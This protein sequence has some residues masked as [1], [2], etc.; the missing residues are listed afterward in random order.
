M[1][2]TELF[3][4]LENQ[5]GEAYFY[6]VFL[7]HYEDIKKD[8]IT[9]QVY[10]NICIRYSKYYEI[11]DNWCLNVAREYFSSYFQASIES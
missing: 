10:L 6:G 3:K 1:N 7:Q 8:V 11:K 4:R 2:N 9:F 5:F